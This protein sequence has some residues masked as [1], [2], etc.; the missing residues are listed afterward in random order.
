MKRDY[1]VRILEREYKIGDLVYV[2]DTAKIKGRAKKL[3]PPWKGPGLVCEKLS[4]YVYK[5]KLQKS[6]LTINH[7]RLKPCKDREVPPWLKQC[8]HR[9]Q[10]GEDVTKATNPDLYC[11]CRKPDDE[12]FMIQCD[13]CNEWYHGAC[14]DL[15][16]ELADTMVKFRCPRSE[17]W[18]RKVTLHIKAN[19]PVV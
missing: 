7:D 16:P 3:D 5:I 13:F 14:V 1:D 2:L 12:L 17:L 18:H 19:I 4:S 11:L 15:T 8:Q 10:D 6:V 9:L